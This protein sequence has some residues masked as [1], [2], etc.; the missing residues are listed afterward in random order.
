VPEGTAAPQLPARP[1]PPTPPE[2]RP[3][4]PQIAPVPPLAQQ[5]SLVN[6]RNYL[7]QMGVFSNIANAEDLKRRLDKAG[8]PAQIEARVQVGPFK[9]KTEAEVAQKK[10]AEMGLS[11]LLVSPRK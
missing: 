6:R 5:Q 11:G 7:V 4:M 8:I 1:T 10:L 2:V 3:V 9:N